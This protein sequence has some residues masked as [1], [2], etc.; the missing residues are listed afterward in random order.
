MAL[1]HVIGHTLVSQAEMTERTRRIDGDLTAFGDALGKANSQNGTVRALPSLR[2][3]T[4]SVTVADYLRTARTSEAIPF[5][6]VGVGK[7][8]TILLRHVYTG[9]FGKKD[10]LLTTAVRDPFMTFNMAPRAINLMPRRVAQKAHIRGAAATANGTELVYYINALTAQSLALTFD[11]SFDDFP[12]ELCERIGGAISIAGSIPVFGPYSGVLIAAGAAIKLMGRLVNA[13]VDA[14]PEFTVTER[15]DFQVPGS[16]IP[17]S[18]YKI[19]SNDSLNHADFN[20]DLRRGLTHKDT[21]RPYDGDEPYIAFLLDGTPNDAFKEF[22][23]TAA[24]A[25]ILS[26]FLNQKEGSEVAIGAVAEAFRV[27]SDLRYRREAD[28]LQHEIG[29][30]PE[31]SDERQILE[32]RRSA[33]IANI[34]ENL[35][36]PDYRFPTPPVE[37]ATQLLG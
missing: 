22:T 18:G 26:R 19:I 31:G 24:S 32:Q 23:P 37:A 11:M 28:R 14:R 33:A 1:S 4:G 5:E 2:F 34:L 20:F 13:L 30:L 10:M 7:P 27:Y 3:S 12:D 6:P 21:G 15:L 36:K 8:A 16:P 29:Q 17:D 9:R 25:A 35:L